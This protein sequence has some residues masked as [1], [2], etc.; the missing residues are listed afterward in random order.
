MSMLQTTIMNIDQKLSSVCANVTLNSSTIMNIDSMG[1]VY[2]NVT[3]NNHE[4]RQLSNDFV[5]VTHNNHD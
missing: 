3:L 4:Y 1:N 5:D 2:V